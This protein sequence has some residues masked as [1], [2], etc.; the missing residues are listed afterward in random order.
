LT[1]AKAWRRQEGLCNLR[2]LVRLHLLLPFAA[3]GLALGFVATALG[4]PH[5]A[6][7]AWA[8]TTAVVL[9]SFLA[10]VVARIGLHAVLALHFDQE[11][12]LYGALAHA[13][14]GAE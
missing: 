7:I 3:F 12:E 9:A 5:V 10:E 4:A 14:G 8:A 2:R 11:D 6:A 13:P 1:A